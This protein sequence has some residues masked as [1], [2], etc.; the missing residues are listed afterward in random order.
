MRLTVAH[1]LFFTLLVATGLV[2]IT[3][4]VLMAWSVERGFVRYVEARQK[5]HIE[6]LVD[7][8]ADVYAE[9]GGWQYLTA[10][11]ARWLAILN[12]GREF[13]PRRRPWMRGME[14]SD[15]LLRRWP[16]ETLPRHL[17]EKRVLPLEFRVMLLD[18]DRKVLYGREEAVKDLDLWPIEVDGRKI[19]FLGVMPGPPLE[20]LGELRFLQRQSQTLWLI[21]ALVVILSAAVAVPVASRLVRRL[22]AFNRGTQALASGH[23][24]TR[25]P[26]DSGD[27]FGQLARDF[28]DLAKALEN[29]EHMRRQWVADISHE[30]RTPLS[31]LRGELEALQDGV[32]PLEAA[33]VDSLHADVLRLSRL[34]DDLYELS[35][36]EIG[37]L[38]YRKQSVDPMEILQDDLDSLAPRFAERNIA[39]RFEPVSDPDTRLHADADR[40]SQLFRNLLNNTLRYTDPGGSIG[41][42]ATSHDGWL[43]LE[44]Q[45]SS[46]GVPDA[47]LPRLFDRFYRVE[48][49]RNREHGGA[50]L[51][52]ALSKNIVEAH[53]GRIEARPSPLGGLWVH[54]ELPLEP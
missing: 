23:Y 38:S 53:D 32:R 43:H 3:L 34:V 9:D 15:D 44:F 54:I 5:E 18:T 7:R 12:G 6:T 16:P 47:E 36:S 35:M 30:L 10:D 2:V 4:V 27:E 14:D 22:R 50:G 51:G 49:S 46:P 31:V 25:L 29:T 37:A 40:L 20:R 52:L 24:D 21:A 11:P 8:L 45:D 1:K 26:V 17:Q 33:A 42:R 28:N 48:A 39:V 41:I 19:G 13:S